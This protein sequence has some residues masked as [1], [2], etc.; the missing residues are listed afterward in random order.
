RPEILEQFRPRLQPGTSDN[1]NQLSS[2]VRICAAIP[3]DHVLGAR[4]SLLKN[5]SQV[6]GQ[7]GKQRNKA[8]IAARMVLGL[9]TVYE[10]SATRPINILPLKRQMFGRTSQSPITAQSE[11]QSPLRVGASTQNLRRISLG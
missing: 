8:R 3:S 2:K 6:R 9:G 4:F 1:A 10:H 7:L 11:Q 5:L